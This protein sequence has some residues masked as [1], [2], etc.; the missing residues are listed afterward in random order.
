MSPSSPVEKVREQNLK[1]FAKGDKFPEAGGPTC[2]ESGNPS[3]RASTDFSTDRQ[4]RTAGAREFQRT[5]LRRERKVIFARTSFFIK[6]ESAIVTTWEKM[7]E[8]SW[9]FKKI[10]K[11]VPKCDTVLISWTLPKWDSFLSR[12]FHTFWRYFH[13]FL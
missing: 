1:P 9:R 8:K 12:Y 4:R 7:I 2:A 10:C 3:Q 5:P 13:T 6:M 11:N